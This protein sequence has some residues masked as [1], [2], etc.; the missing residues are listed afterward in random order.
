MGHAV[1][2]RYIVIAVARRVAVSIVVGPVDA[3]ICRHVHGAVRC[4]VVHEDDLVYVGVHPKVE[5]R[6]IVCRCRLFSLLV[7]SRAPDFDSSNV[8]EG[9]IAQRN[10]E[11]QVIDALRAWKG[12]SRLDFTGPNFF[13]C[14]SFAISS[15]V[16]QA[17]E[18]TARGG[19]HGKGIVCAIR[20]GREGNV[21]TG[22]SDARLGQV[23]VGTSTC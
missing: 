7:G 1:E 4:V 12:C 23:A 22:S 13:P 9:G 16:E 6:R 14:A 10:A 5:P 15:A 20:I 18:Q 19:V 8:C 11:R 21:H 17:V 3:A 2:L